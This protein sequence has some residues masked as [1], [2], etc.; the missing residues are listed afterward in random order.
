MSKD[1]SLRLAVIGGGPGG[2]AA[3]FRA[4]A[5]GME[6]TLVDPQKNPGGVC[7]YW[8][9]IPTKALLHVVKVKDEARAA[10]EWGVSFGEP[11]VDIDKLRSFKDGVIDKLT[12]GLGR[13]TK[14]R[15]IRHLRGY[16]R[17]E[18]PGALTIDLVE[19]DTERVEFDKA[20]VAAGASPIS[21]PNVELES[22]RILY[23][24]S[25]LDLEEIPETLLVVGGG[26]I[27]LE[28]GSVYGKLGAK[29]SIV[30]M[31]DGIMPGADRDLVGIFEK[32]NEGV[33][34]EVMT[35]TVVDTIEEAKKGLKVT[36]KPTSGEGKGRSKTYSKVLLAV[37][38]RPNIENLGL[39]DAGVETG[40]KGFVNVDAQRRTNVESIYAVGDITGPPL[41]AHK[42]KLEGRV[43]AEAIAGEPSAYDPATIPSV[44][45]TDPEI[46]WCGVT[47]TE[48]K[49]QGLDVTVSSFPWAASG[50]AAAMGTSV[51]K[52][53][54]IVDNTTERVLGVG[55]VGKDAGE[56][57]PEGVLALEMAALA[58]D[59]ELTVHPHPTLSETI[60]E[61][62]A[63]FYGSPTDMMGST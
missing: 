62:A 1:E 2:Y 14:K 52:T 33:F 40:E 48:A 34:E 58:K 22:D 56:L 4:A 46:A 11:K 55:I 43:A 19:G 20:I 12:D 60:M 5:F 61:A 63:A 57:I 18:G 30:E 24:R 53:K 42:A 49:D 17:F 25:A 38:H 44:E 35:N 41:L 3:A 51:G 9:C 15:K 16:G 45:Y 23:A 50:R 29:V 36:F 27:G 39:E 8:G 21:L 6:V 54:L 47:E 26:Y 28:L 10:K 59:L 37:G 7:L 13:L 32:A 31:M